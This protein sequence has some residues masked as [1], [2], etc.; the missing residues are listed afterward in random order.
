VVVQD[1]ITGSV[2]TEQTAGL[3]NFDNDNDA[4]DQ[5]FLDSWALCVDFLVEAG[6]LFT[7][8]FLA[9]GMVVDSGMYALGWSTANA[10][11]DM[12]IPLLVVELGP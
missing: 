3:W 1:A 9:S 11:M 10:W 8:A 2:L 6:Q 12:R 4:S 7:V 5:G